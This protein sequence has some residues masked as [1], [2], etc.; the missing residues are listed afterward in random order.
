MSQSAP[1]GPEVRIRIGGP[2][3]TGIKAA[4]QSLA[5]VFASSGYHTFDLTEYPS[6]I[7]G[8]HNTYHLRVSEAPIY[9][10]VMATDV[11]VALD[12]QTVRLH[13]AELTEG[14]AVIYDPADFEPDA[15]D[16]DGRDDLCLV[17]AP[18]TAIVKDVGGIPIMRNVVSLGAVLGHMD[19]PLQGL[20]DSIRAQFANKPAEVAEQ[21]V[22]AATAGYAFAQDVHCDFPYKLAPRAAEAD[23]VL[24]DGNESVGLGA[25]A[26]GIG[27]YCAYPM[28]PSSA[29]LHFMAKYG[30]DNGVV[31]KHTEDEIAAMNMV[32]GGAFG[33]ARSMCATAGGGFAL[34]VE[35]FGFGGVSE[36]AV[37]VGVFTR[38][39]PATGMPTW[40]EQ[41]DLRFVIHAAQGEFP[42]VV[43]APGDHTESFEAGWKAF[44]LADQL[45][46]PV[47]ILSDS[48][49]CENR[50]TSVPY[51][52]D[53]VTIDRGALV[54]EGD[55]ASHPE[56]IA[57]AGGYLRYKVTESGISTRAL[58][59]VTGATQLVNS[60]EHDEYGWG[61]EGE[62]ADVRIAQNDK[63]MKKLEL[64]RTLVPPPNHF[65][66][67]SAEVSI[68]CFGSTK[69]PVREAMS[70]LEAEGITVN[71]LQPV[72]VWPFPHEE[73][74]AFIDSAARTLVIESN[75]TG[76]LEGLV[77]EYCGLH[78][79][80][81]LRRY[82]GRPIS[83]EIV[84]AK[85]KAMLGAQVELTTAGAV[86]AKEGGL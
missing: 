47:V 64:A 38:P 39:G 21:N 86:A 56:A 81:N 50:Q 9:S 5:R 44:N 26:A 69:M 57:E 74:A 12:R 77:A 3:G 13:L 66:P 79:D 31:V 52:V 60:Y 30:D 49:L 6:L 15:S 40:T 43:L 85:V 42:R 82:D 1:Y 78:F 36:S 72:T 24:A 34:M 11:L 67:T 8:G 68:V 23:V 61:Q 51:D 53:A 17:P 76:Q 27:L 63:R 58:P 32:L 54:A 84:Y 28:T 37:V 22:A 35:A 20:L 83:P 4:G 25:L 14:A 7:K 65:G 73:V 46:T 75:Y 16:I 59:G 55:V 19:Y 80:A 48:Y 71:M 45:Q 33:G 70:W 18:L 62:R 41:S 10:H 29:L 2:A